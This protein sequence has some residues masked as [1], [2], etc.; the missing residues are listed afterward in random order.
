MRFASAISK[1]ADPAQAL[2]S[3]VKEISQRLGSHTADVVF[4]FVSSLYRAD[5]SQLL[6]ETRR[7]LQFPLLLG[8][9]A[10]GVLG[11]DQELEAMP[12]L[13]L[14]AA[15]L[16]DV[17]LHPFAV[18]PSDL[19]EAQ[20]PGYW[21]EKIGVN[22][23]KNPV[24]VLL[25]EPFSCDVMR[26]VEKLNVA[27]PKLPLVGGLASGANR[28]GESALFF[29][30][31]VIGEG[32]VGVLLTGNVTLQTIVSQ[33]TRPIGRTYLVTKAKENVILELA[34]SP[35]LE[36]L[37]KLIQS[38]S[39]VDRTLAQKALLLGVVMNEYKEKFQRGDFLIRNLIGMDPSSGALAVGD[40]IQVGQTVQFQV[41]D[42]QTSRE[43]LQA[44]LNEQQE[45]FKKDPSAGALLFSCLGRG[46]DLYGESHYDI[47]TIQSATGDLPIAGF[48]CNG[49][50]GPI[51][52]HNYIH[53]FTSSLG[54]FRPFKQTHSSSESIA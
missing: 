47:R 43:D 39:P 51:D 49:E 26:L 11:V 52:G 32:A 54:L 17:E 48:F 16:P 5:W 40:R 34:G 6:Q 37:Q 29:N 3:A 41:R 24:G 15:H 1:H 42:A 2:K 14:V 50:I 45:R 33:G 21:I 46:H 7:Q 53:G 20:D 38:L 23:S 28:A 19:T 18:T 27:Y 35:A 10:G 36:A 44:L 4:V 25:P 9:T 8:C 31:E 22:P 30:Q 12:A 13:S